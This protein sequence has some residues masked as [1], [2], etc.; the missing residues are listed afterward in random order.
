[1]ESRLKTTS[2]PMQTDFQSSFQRNLFWPFHLYKTK[3]KLKQE[4]TVKIK[5][6]FPSAVL[7]FVIGEK[8]FTLKIWVS[9]YLHLVW[10]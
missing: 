3:N 9:L 10:F 1:M 2:A 8:I 6:G 5:M 4:T 7:T